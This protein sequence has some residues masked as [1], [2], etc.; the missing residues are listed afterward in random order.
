MPAKKNHQVTQIRIF[1]SSPSD[2]QEER[3]A[4]EKVITEDLQR[5]IGKQN[6]LHI[7]PLRW[8]NIVRPGLGD[9]QRQVSE[10]MGEYD[11]FIGIFWKRFGTP[12]ATHESGSEQEFRE[13]YKL[14]GRG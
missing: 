8:E 2:V 12:T 3:D 7:E 1:I 11:I 4:L 6:G 14:M 13:A 9:I 10:Q 5:T